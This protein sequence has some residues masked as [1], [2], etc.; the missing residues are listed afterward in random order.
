MND[1]ESLPLVKQ[2]RFLERVYNSNITSNVLSFPNEVS[3]TQI[4]KEVLD[5][6]FVVLL[7]ESESHPLEC[8]VHSIAACSGVAGLKCGIM[9]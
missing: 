1:V 3:F 2:C 8:L 7:T 6:D 5:K 9:P 4:K